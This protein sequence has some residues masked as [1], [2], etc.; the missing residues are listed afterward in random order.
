MQV[1]YLCDIMT[2][3][4]VSRGPQCW[5]AKVVKWLGHLLEFLMNTFMPHV[6]W[7]VNWAISCVIRIVMNVQL[8][9]LLMDFHRV[10]VVMGLWEDAQE[11]C[12]WHHD[13]ATHG[14]EWEEVN[15]RL[16]WQRK[17]NASWMEIISNCASGMLSYM[18]WNLT[19]QCTW[20]K[21]QNSNVL[22]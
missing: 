15:V 21:G 3:W 18:F 9:E 20:I 1:L 6:W 13:K 2:W 4:H 17:L 8:L 12:L 5:R 22:T 16:A 10:V 11:L 19:I 7:L 14:Q